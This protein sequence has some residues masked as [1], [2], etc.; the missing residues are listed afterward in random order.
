MNVTFVG[1]AVPVVVAGLILILVAGRRDPDPDRRRTEARYLGA[2]CFLAVFVTLFGAYT[3]VAQLSTFVVDR[4]RSSEF[5]YSPADDIPFIVGNNRPSDDA[6]WRGTVQAALLTAAATGVLMF[7]RGRRRAV[8]DRSDFAGSVA[9]R[10]DAAYL[11]VACFIAAFLI[12][13]ALTFGIYGLFRALAPGVTGVGNSDIE[14]QRGVAQ[15]IS[16]VALAGGALMVFLV[17]WRDRSAT[18]DAAPEAARDDEPP[19]AVTMA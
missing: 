9:E 14:R 19:P 16:L 15:A 2:A 3:V 6:I 8:R 12:L 5:S 7:H 10:V 13:A 11:Y 4:D 1:F 17:H 18:D